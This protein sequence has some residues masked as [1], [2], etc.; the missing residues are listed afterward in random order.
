VDTVRN[1]PQ[2]TRNLES[3]TKNDANVVIAKMDA[4]ANGTPKGV[5]IQGFPTLMFWDANNNQHPYKGERDLVALKKFV[6]SQRT[7]TP[8]S[9]TEKQD[10]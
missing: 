4:T 6:D 5:A 9:E 2:C 8:S 10:L 1:W 7:S 3:F